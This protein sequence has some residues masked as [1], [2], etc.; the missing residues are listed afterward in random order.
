MREIDPRFRHADFLGRSVGGC[1]ESQ[2]A[3]VCKAD[4]FGGDDYQAPGDVEGVF[5]GLQ[6]A[7]EVVEGGVRVGAADGF[8]EGGD[9]V[10]V[11]VAGAV[12]DEGF[13]EGGFD[14][15]FGCVGAL[16]EILSNIVSLERE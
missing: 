11:L 4:V 6:H 5:A 7:G 1:G 12:V 8:V 10:V 14:G 15:G 9:G 16:G 2:H 3:V 13:G